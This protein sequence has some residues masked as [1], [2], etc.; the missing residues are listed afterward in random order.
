MKN[1]SFG[2]L[3]I[4]ALT[5][6]TGDA[7]AR[8][9]GPRSA[10][11]LT[12]APA[13]GSEEA[14]VTIILF[15]NFR[16]SYGNY[17]FNGFQAVQREFPG[18]FRLYFKHHAINRYNRKGLLAGQAAMAAHA[19]GKFWDMAEILF[20]NRYKL[21]PKNLETY[22][23]E[24]GLKLKPF[25]KAMRKATYEARVKREVVGSK[26]FLRGS[27]SCPV[28]WV[29]G[30]QMSGYVSAYRLKRMLRAAALEVRGIRIRPLL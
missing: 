11:N 23:Q 16:C 1:L 7:N 13:L 15:Y 28:V 12:T 29:N 3:T 30:K 26:K 18:M 10:L 24:L 22:A 4:I 2:L 17:V 21:S 20:R 6:G 14:L 9:P 19:Q 8:K 27:T 5:L 25:K